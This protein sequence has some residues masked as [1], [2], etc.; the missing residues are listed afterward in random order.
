MNKYLWEMP[1]AIANTHNELSDF[2]PEKASAD[3]LVMLFLDKSLVSVCAIKR[4]SMIT[5]RFII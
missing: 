1:L 2:R 4:M 3:I 5:L